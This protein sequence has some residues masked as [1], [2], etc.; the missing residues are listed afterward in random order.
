MAAD[1]GTC[2]AVSATF[3]SRHPLVGQLAY[4]RALV[5]GV[6]IQSILTVVD[7]FNTHEVV[8]YPEVNGRLLATAR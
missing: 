4:V 5:D 3:S 7:E 6:P 2:R 8:G 1:V